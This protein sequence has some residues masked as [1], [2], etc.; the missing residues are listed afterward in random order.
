MK[1]LFKPQWKP[2]LICNAYITVNECDQ[3]I[4]KSLP[5]YVLDITYNS[6]ECTMEEKSKGTSIYCH[7]CLKTFMV[8]CVPNGTLG[9][10]LDLAIHRNRSTFILHLACNLYA[11]LC[12]VF[13]Q[14]MFHNQSYQI[15]QGSSRQRTLSPNQNNL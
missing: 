14:F 3:G 2:I 9:R 4:K 5:N 12:Q 11:Y 7:G 10:S 8:L 15:I 13:F 1:L 6:S